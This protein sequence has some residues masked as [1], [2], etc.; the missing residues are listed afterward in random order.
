[1][2][3][4]NQIIDTIQAGKKQVVNTFVTDAKFK[5]ELNKLIDAQ[6]EFAKGSVD[7]SIAIARAFYNKA[8]EAMKSVVPSYTK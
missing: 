7:S 1:M 2:F 4:H 6:T 3:T 5:E 8:N